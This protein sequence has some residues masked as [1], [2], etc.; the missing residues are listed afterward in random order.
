[1]AKNAS[2]QLSKSSLI[3]SI[4]CSK[5]LY[6]Y[7]HFYQ[8]R[9]KV[10]RSQQQ[11]FDRGQKVG[12]LARELFPGGKDLTPP[13]VFAYDQSVA[14]TK[15]LISNN[16]P[17]MYEAAFRYNGILV[18]LDILVHKEGKWYA[19]EVKSSLK[20]S[21]TYLQ[22]T[23][24]QHYIITQCGLELEDFFIVHINGNFV[25]H[26][27]IALED[28]F[29]IQSVKEHALEQQPYIEQVIEDARK[30]IQADEIPEVE[31]GE[32]C[33]RP[34]SC[35]FQGYCWKGLQENPVFQLSALPLA[36]KV[37]LAKSGIQ[38]L[39]DIPEESI[40]GRRQQNQWQ[41]HLHQKEIIDF[42]ALK[43]FF[44]DA[45]YP[46]YF[47][48]IEAAQPA[49]PVFDG[50]SPFQALP[51][52]FSLH[53]KAAEN[54]PL[55]HF[56]YI[57][58]PGWDGRKQFLE[59]FLEY[60]QSPGVIVVFNTLL[61]KGILYQ[62]GKLFPEYAHDIKERMTRFRD[63]EQ[64]FKNDAYYHPAMNG[65]YSMKAIL[66]AID[67]RL[68]YQQLEVKD[69]SDAMLLYA[70]L[71]PEMPE[72][73][74]QKALTQ[75]KDYCRMDTLAVSYVYEYLRKKSEIADK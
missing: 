24:I 8:L 11:I 21:R 19:Y 72:D 1:M 9:D 17:V 51:F 13:S 25:R 22:D 42:V 74:L 43:S 15:A 59:M 75:L 28:L 67:P 20:I 38:S 53:Y 35:D 66:P 40:S 47:F 18:A 39:K 41:A 58:P 60:T 14:A 73:A 49:I 50:T 30:T 61:E 65:A 44:D 23:A 37:L 26:G 55:Q 36:E 33:F 57:I 4:Q 56:E 7:K 6:L 46:V 54:E 3:R 10:S 62:L 32:Q 16:F 34:Y 31:I 63:I 70:S 64:I 52:Q 69:G 2:V 12:L 5:S 29:K 27:E 71:H 45:T 68:G 48:D